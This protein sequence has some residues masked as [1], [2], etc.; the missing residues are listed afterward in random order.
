[1]IFSLKTLAL[2]PLPLHGEAFKVGCG[3]SGACIILG[4][5]GWGQAWCLL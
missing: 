2:L 1:M 3:Q 5:A 4:G